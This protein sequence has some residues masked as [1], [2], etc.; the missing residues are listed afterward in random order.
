MCGEYNWLTYAEV[1]ARARAF[2]C[3]LAALGQQVKENILLFSETKA[4]WIISAQGCFAQNF[5]GKKWDIFVI[6]SEFKHNFLF[7]FVLLL[8]LLLPF[9]FSLDYSNHV[10][11]TW[12]VEK[13][14]ILKSETLNLFQN[15]YIYSLYSFFKIP[16]YLLLPLK[17]SVHVTFIPSPSH[18]VI[19]SFLPQTPDVVYKKYFFI[20]I[21]GEAHSKM[22]VFFFLLTKRLD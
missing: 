15:N 10:L 12:Q 20:N 4:E 17:W 13:T 18:I 22:A 16:I 19:S 3:G 1:D 8:V 11:S 21:K 14:Y 7:C 2:G 6:V 9:H 5:P